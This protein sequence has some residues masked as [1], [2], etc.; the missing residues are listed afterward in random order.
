M[1]GIKVSQDQGIDSLER[2]AKENGVKS[3]DDKASQRQCGL[4]S[5]V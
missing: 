4:W 2:Q 3:K 5:K 1:E